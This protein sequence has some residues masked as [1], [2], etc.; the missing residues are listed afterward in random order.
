MENPTKREADVYGEY[1]IGGEIT[2]RDFQKFA[3]RIDPKEF[4]A[5]A[6]GR[7]KFRGFWPTGT[8]KRSSMPV[9]KKMWDVFQSLNLLYYYRKYICKY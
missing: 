1:I 8:L 7:K 5:I 4:W 2:E 9:Q 3:P 6:L